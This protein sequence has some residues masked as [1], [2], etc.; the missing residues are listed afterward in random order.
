MPAKLPALA[1]PGRD[2]VRR[3]SNA[4]TFRFQTRQLFISDALLQE[5]I[6][7]E[8]AGDGIWS[9]CFGDVLLAWLDERDLRLHA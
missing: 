2:L 1:H 4:G 5:N 3:V 9:I 8:Q 7:L 6:A